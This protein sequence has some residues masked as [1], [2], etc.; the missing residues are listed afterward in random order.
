MDAR[1]SMPDITNATSDA[2]PDYTAYSGLDVLAMLGFM[3]LVM[4]LLCLLFSNAFKRRPK[5]PPDTLN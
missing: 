4:G 5:Y 1:N 3:V 2:P